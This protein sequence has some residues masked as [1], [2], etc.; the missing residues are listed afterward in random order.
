MLLFRNLRVRTEVVLELPSLPKKRRKTQ[1]PEDDQISK[2]RA[3]CGF[4]VNSP[5]MAGPTN[6]KN[7]YDSLRTEIDGYIKYSDR[8]SIVWANVYYLLRGKTR[9]GF[10]APIKKD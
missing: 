3:S 2:A 7:H 5:D 1:L 4:S 10:V 8:W 6:P 9:G